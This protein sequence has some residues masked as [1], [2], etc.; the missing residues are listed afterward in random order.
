M[1]IRTVGIGLFWLATIHAP[2]LISTSRG[3]DFVEGG[4]FEKKGKPF[5][6]WQVQAEKAKVEVNRPAGRWIPVTVSFNSDDCQKVTLNIGAYSH[7]AGR[8][9]VDNVQAKGF[10]V[11]NPSFEELQPDGEGFV[12]WNADR[13]GE[14]IHT[15]RERASDGKVSALYQDPSF[16]AR[17]IR[18][19]QVV[20]VK[21]HTDYSYTFD[22]YMDDDFYAAIRCSVIAAPPAAYRVLKGDI[23]PSIDDL[24]ADRSG[25]GYQQCRLALSGGHASLTQKLAVPVDRNLEAGASVKTKENFNGAVKLSVVD[26]ESGRL[27]ASTSIADTKNLWESV[28]LRFTSIS[29]GVSLRIAGEGGGNVLLDGAYLSTPRLRPAAQSIEWGAGSDSFVFDDTAA[30]DFQGE[31]AEI[32]ETGL[33][34]LRK[35][36]AR[37]GVALAESPATGAPLA[38]RIGDDLMA[39]REDSRTEAYSLNVD[40]SGVRITAANERGAFYGIMTLLQLLDKN[41]RGEPIAFAC[42]IV[43][44]PDV[45][46]RALNRGAPGLT[47]EWMARRKANMAFHISPKDIPDFRRH[48]IEAIPHDNVTHYPYSKAADEIL[49]NPNYAEGMGRTDELTLIGQTPA[50]LT[51]RNVLRTKLTDI[52]V[53]SV[54][55][56]TNYKEGRDYRVIPG[57]LKM[58]LRNPTSFEPDGAAFAIA[59]VP[60]SRIADGTTVKAAYEHVAVGHNFC[61]ELCLAELAPQEVVAENAR[62]MVAKHDLS[63]IGLHVSESPRLVG[64]GP[65]CR[66]T[67]LSASQLIARYYERLDKAVKHAN[68]ECR[69]ITHADD[70]LPWQHAIGTGWADAPPLLPKDIIQSCWHYNPGDSLAYVVKTARLFSELGHAFFFVPFYDYRNIHVYAAGALWARSKGMPCLGLSDWSYHLGPY[71]PLQEPAPFIEEALSCAWRAPREGEKGYVDPAEFEAM[72]EKIVRE[73]QDH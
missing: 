19:S 57:E 38:I 39:V 63:Y 20:N 52:V 21:P 67:G 61:G 10:K 36:L 12:A 49:R 8:C 64:K 60:E 62:L 32:V 9:W 6:D 26:E 45:P 58:S 15:S 22:L 69:I 68:P 34:I 37:M 51:G 66:A 56:R 70:F 7:P 40:G 14:W 48:G 4:D 53:N 50:E 71:A 27:L 5:S 54:D 13:P 41:S 29:S 2:P 3:A 31:S 11:T 65:R 43:D 46:W 55:G 25:A 59:R 18:L 24:I 1:P 73:A 72:L 23:K 47:A 30:F 33:S 16:A 42:R 44:W 17:M 35:D 28:T